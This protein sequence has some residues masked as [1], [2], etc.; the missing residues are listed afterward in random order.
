MEH[1]NN[2]CDRNNVVMVND[3]IKEVLAKRFNLARIDMSP[4]TLIVSGKS[5]HIS[6]TDAFKEN[7]ELLVQVINKAAFYNREP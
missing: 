4:E 6:K 1:L 5:L 7:M 2:F 3:S